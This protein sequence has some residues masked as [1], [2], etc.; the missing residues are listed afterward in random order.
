MTLRNVVVVGLVAIVVLA[1]WA[2]KR[3]TAPAQAPPQ[4]SSSAPAGEAMPPSGGTMPPSGSAPPVMVESGGDP[5]VQWQVPARWGQGE[6][7]AMRLATYSIPAGGG[8]SDARCAVYYFGP[9]QGGGVENNVERWIGEFESGAKPQRVSRTVDGMP[10]STVRVRGTYVAHAAMGGGGE[11][12]PQPHHELYGAVVEGPNG[13]LFFKL[14]GPEKT[15]EAAA[16]DFD[17]MLGSLKKK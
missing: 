15:V 9:G 6:S 7:S 14:T 5:G 1:V 13:A 2:W 11:S 17:R 8:A 3:N 12:G 10:V 4:A 16:G